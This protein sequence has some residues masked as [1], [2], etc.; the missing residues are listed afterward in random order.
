MVDGEYMSS[1]LRW[2]RTIIA[3][4]PYELQQIVQEP[5][6]ESESEGLK[7]NK[8]QIWWPKTTHQYGSVPLV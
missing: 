3:N 8:R 5:I 6:D 7:M 2:R 4:T 1:S